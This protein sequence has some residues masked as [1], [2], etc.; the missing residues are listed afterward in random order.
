MTA[1]G[2]KWL[3]DK[4]RHYPVVIDAAVTVATSTS[5][6]AMGTSFQ[7]KII[8][9]P[10]TSNYWSFYY[11]GSA[12]A[13]ASSPDGVTW[14]VRGS[15]AYNTFHFALTQRD[16]TSTVFL[17]T[18]CGSD[19]DICVRKGTIAGT[20]ISWTD[21]VTA[22]DGT[23]ATTNAY[24]RPNIALSRN[25]YIWVAA[26]KQTAASTF[27][28]TVRNSTNV[29]DPSSW[30]T[31]ST[32]GSSETYLLDHIL[33][34]TTYQNMYLVVNGA[35]GDRSVMG[36]T[37]NGSTWTS[38]VTGGDG[39]VSG[40]N[41]VSGSGVASGD[42]IGSGYSVTKLVFIGT[43]LYS[44]GT[45]TNAA[46]GV[47]VN[48][49]AKWIGTSWS[50]LWTGMNGI[51]Y[52][53]VVDASGNLYAGGNFTTSGGVTTN[54]IAKWNG[55]SWS[56]L[57]G[58][59]N[60]T[61]NALAF[62]GTTLYVGGTFSYVNGS[63]I[64][65]QYIAR[66]SGS[67]SSLG[68]TLA[69]AVTSLAVSGTNLYAGGQFG[70][71][72]GVMV[73]GI[74]KWNG[75][76]WSALGAGLPG[77]ANRNCLAFSGT[78]LYAGGTF[79]GPRKW[80]GT[81]W[82]AL[83][84]GVTSSYSLGF[85]GSDLYTSGYFA[86]VNGSDGQIGK[87][88]LSAAT[89]A[90]SPSVAQEIST[91]SDFSDVTHLLYVDG[92]ANVKYKKFSGGT[93]T[94]AVTLQTGSATHPSIGI[95]KANGDL[96]AFW[97]EG[98]TI[99]YKKGVAPYGAGNWD[100]NSTSFYSTGTND[101]I[102]V[103]SRWDGVF[104]QWVNGTGNPYGVIFDKL[105]AGTSNCFAPP[106][107]ALY[108][109]NHCAILG[110]VGG[111]DDGDILLSPGKTLTVNAGQTITWGPGKSI[112]IPTGASIIINNTGQL[113]QTNQWMVDADGDGYPASTSISAQTNSPG[114]T[115]VRRKTLQTY[116]TVDANDGDAATH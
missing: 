63:S 6:N 30:N 108:V 114:G 109:E 77:T 68:P 64:F 5:A 31:A 67:W 74:S 57:G 42:M 27:I 3:T 102:S 34:P 93:W 62:V 98:N 33:V 40:W 49:I 41:A 104:L 81:S 50:A 13:Y 70:T 110:T 8:F 43:D 80:N 88:G 23:N 39:G 78:D 26:R 9:N 69:G 87:W 35:G 19:L 47:R 99:K 11:D 90:Y 36:Y 48:S 22:L 106:G 10:A 105:S 7:S 16:P 72:N 58:G 21:E 14:T 113:K 66:W 56:A 17:A 86:T 82:S 52:T 107:G 12:I 46:G 97:M 112:K 4:R 101:T 15:L 55:T 54:Y 91:V 75:T 32:V 59:T 76:S 24:T 96:Y 2:K 20:V 103:G 60:A 92:S 83:G 37:Y 115:Y 45:L 71:I 89:I 61:V 84:S 28:S 29:E 25:G 85:L 53:L 111:V 1:E 73:N 116:S 18:Q 100:S 65:A 94:T 95:N 79:V 38:A 44:E 51:V